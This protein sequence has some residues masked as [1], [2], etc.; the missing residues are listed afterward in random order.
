MTRSVRIWAAILAPAFLVLAIVAAGAE[1]GSSGAP[2][3]QG[4]ADCDGAVDAGD[5]LAVLW[6]IAGPPGATA[7]CAQT[8][9]DTDCSGDVDTTD[10]LAILRY[11]AG[12]SRATSLADGCPP[13]GGPA[14]TATPALTDTGSAIPTE[15]GPPTPS[16]TET[17]AALT[18]TPFVTASETTTLTG[19]ATPTPTRSAT[20]TATVT[21]TP[22]P[23]PTVRPTLSPTPTPTARPAC[24]ALPAADGGVSVAAV[25][26]ANNY[27]MTLLPADAGVDKLTNVVPVPNVPG[28]AVITREG[29][30]IWTVCLKNDDQRQLL[31]DLSDVVRDIHANADSDEGL[32]GFAFDPSDA[33]I[34]Y[35]DYSMPPD[36]GPTA[37]APYLSGNGTPAPNTVRS[38]ISRFHIVGGE[39]D[40]DNE[41]VILDIYQ[42]WEWH[43]A[44]GLEFGPDGMLYIGSGDGGSNSAKG[45]SLDDLWGAI[46]RIDVHS[47]TPYSIP[48]DNP[49]VASP[50]TAAK[51]V[52]AYGLRNPWRFS[53]DSAPGGKMWIA[54]VGE[55]SY[56]EVDIGQAGANYGWNV[57]EGYQ[58][59]AP[60]GGTPTPCSTAGL[61]TPR[62]VYTHA[63]GN[64]AIQG[65]YVYH[66]SAMPELDG[67]FIYGDFCTGRIW[68]VDTQ[69]DQSDP[70]L[71]TDSDIHPVS[72]AITSDGDIVAVNYTRAPYF[73]G[74][75]GVYKL[76]RVN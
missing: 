71:L 46:L 38:R 7:A 76:E 20:P 59:F 70:I 60:P 44:D 65:G 62:A 12:D 11:L 72:W 21:P 63:G 47:G 58:C 55:N 74:T 25:P 52:W 43:N 29:G 35:V 15:S 6:Q 54:D 19:T 68:A 13:I 27:K 66:G 37:T 33:S 49:F 42:P 39:L 1:A 64:C 24:G 75:P 22:T 69:D 3:I 57:M 73:L 48:P 2:P 32:V 45:Q 23:T 18:E 31:A 28:L 30:Q 16:P 8:S 53:F 40:R 10:V 67:Y 41:E 9:G 34:V 61:S 50:T 51:E 26:Q 14:A 5:A 4:D 56:E 36:D 17:V